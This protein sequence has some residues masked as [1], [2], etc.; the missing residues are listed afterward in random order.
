M[1]ES[2][3]VHLLASARTWFVTG[4]R[5]CVQVLSDPRFSAK[6]GQSLRV[7]SHALPRTML[8]A[9]PP[10]HTRLRASV[11]DAFNPGAMAVARTSMQP[12]VAES[13]HQ[14][15]AVLESGAE[16]DLVSELAEPLAVRVLGGFLGLEDSDLPDLASW[17]RAVSVNL[18]PFADPGSGDVSAVQMQDM[19]ERFAD[20]LYAPTNPASALAVLSR[21][22]AA[23]SISPAEALATAALLVVG[24]L[25][26]LAGLA[27]NAV[28]ALLATTP[29]ATEET[30][31][32]RTAVDELLRFDSPIQFSAR[33]ATELAQL[34]KHQI[35]AGDHVVLLLGAANRDPARFADPDCVV[36]D[37][38]TNPHL[39][40]GA[41]PHVCLG[42]PL[43]RL[44]G[45]LI[46][47]ALPVSLP[48]IEVVTEV[49]SDAV[50]PRRH[51][52]LVL[53]RSG[54]HL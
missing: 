51:S 17:G 48:R 27:S 50:V 35:S 9:D 53:R 33:M 41:G 42:A 8:T 26:P 13:M 25:E 40:F 47:G 44:F 6:H 1:R 14:L 45:E 3:P 5:E 31:R 49:R 7:R 12:M 18:D 54:H 21:S 38:R 37:R 43:V 28:A 46:M 2:D 29:R 36:L 34:G 20:L 24:G 16:I 10:E 19:L 22:H 32:A 52:H 11:S 30:A 4:H 39:S 23:G 15:G